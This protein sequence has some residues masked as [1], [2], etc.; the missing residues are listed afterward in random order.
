MRFF[1][2]TRFSE[3]TAVWT[4]LMVKKFVFHKILCF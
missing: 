1:V 4:S 2:L 3:E